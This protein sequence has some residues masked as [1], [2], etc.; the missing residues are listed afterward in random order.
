MSTYLSAH[1][2]TSFDVKVLR[3]MMMLMTMMVV[4]VMMLMTMMVVTVM[5]VMVIVAVIGHN[6]VH[7]PVSIY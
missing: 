2:D 5:V 6:Q 7:I 4:T 3:T 1:T